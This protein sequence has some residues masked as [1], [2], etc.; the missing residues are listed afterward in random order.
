MMH[1]PPR[2]GV[3]LAAY[4]GMD[5]LPAQ[6]ESILAQEG[7]DVSVLVS[8]DCSSDGTEAWVANMAAQNPRI[9]LLPT[10]QR[11]GRAAPNFFHLLRQMPL[12]Q[13]DYIALADQDD[14][15]HSDKLLRAHQVLQNT[16]CV[17]YS[18]NVTA[19]WP[20]GRE[21]L[22]HKAQ[23]QQPWDFL[24]E[25]PGPGCTFVLRHDFAVALQAAVHEQAQALA[26]IDFHD[27]LIYAWARAQGWRW[28]IDDQ[29]HMRYRQHA[30]NQLGAN[31]G[32]QSLW[33]RAQQ[34]RNGWWMGQARLVAQAIGWRQHP[35]VQPWY[36]GRRWG[37]IWLATHAWRCRRR[38]RDQWLF[39]LS[40]LWLVCKPGRSTAP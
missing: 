38:R 7:V 16:Q 18:S 4:N 8:V 39:A 13:V 29:S 1:S 33:Q 22:I 10:G 12:D 2:I 21:A 27:W 34:V 6:M 9:T 32:W 17:A 15:W 37:L 19:F 23:P 24:F 26:G 11:F 35:F 14:I 20:D 5:Y 36:S 31:T 3:L 40:C 28:H 25:A 30:N